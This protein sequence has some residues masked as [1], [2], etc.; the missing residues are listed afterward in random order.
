VI[1]DQI[2][3]LPH[4]EIIETPDGPATVETYTVAHTRD[5]YRM[6]IVVGR[7][8]AGRRFC[9]QYAKRRGYAEGDGGG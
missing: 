5:G 3:A 7:D 4:P 1:Q 9:R 2:N 8:D 6:G